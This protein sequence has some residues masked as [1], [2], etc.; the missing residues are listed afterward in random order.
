MTFCLSITGS[1]SAFERQYEGS[2]AKPLGAANGQ[3]WNTADYYRGLYSSF[4]DAL[5]QESSRINGGGFAVAPGCYNTVVWETAY[6]VKGYDKV[7]ASDCLPHY[8]RGRAQVCAF[9]CVCA[10]WKCLSFDVGHF[11][12]VRVLAAPGSSEQPD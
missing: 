12:H 4:Y 8:Y 7:Q 5:E 10:I 11:R 1:W 3:H 9:V 2:P 6:E